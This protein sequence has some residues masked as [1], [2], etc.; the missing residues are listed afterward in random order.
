MGAVL[1][2]IAD[3]L[4]LP[5]AVEALQYVARGTA[6]D[7]AFFRDVAVLAV[8]VLG[9]VVVAAATLHRRTA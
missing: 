9:A 3:V 6:P 5:Y 8:F 4:P 7:A 1:Q 2:W